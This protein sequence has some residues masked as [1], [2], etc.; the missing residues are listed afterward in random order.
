MIHRLPKLLPRT[1][2]P[3]FVDAHSSSGGANCAWFRSGILSRTVERDGKV[4]VSIG[5]RPR[6]YQH[7]DRI[8][9]YVHSTSFSFPKMST[10]ALALYNFRRLLLQSCGPVTTTTYPLK[11]MAQLTRHPLPEPLRHTSVHRKSN[12][13]ETSNP[14]ASL[15]V[16][17]SI[18]RPG[19]CCPRE[20]RV[21]RL[22]VIHELATFLSAN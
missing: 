18:G 2:Q 5:K 22:P 3:A 7:S 13:D 21:D 6:V 10:H 20:R 16:S 14:H 12:E 9:L 11:R 17:P 1:A 15:V 4:V 8:W 19:C